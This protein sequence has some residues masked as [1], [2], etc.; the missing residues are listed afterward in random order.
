ME[1]KAKNTVVEEPIQ[2]Q[3]NKNNGFF[4]KFGKWF[5]IAV[6]G[7][8]LFGT[9]YYFGK[10]ATSTTITETETETI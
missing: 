9:G 5:G 3:E 10:R 7:A 2:Q 6:A 1:E 4:K 8:G